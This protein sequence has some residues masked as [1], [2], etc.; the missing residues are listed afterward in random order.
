MIF[1]FNLLFLLLWLF[2]SCDYID[3]VNAFF[4][5]SPN[6]RFE[7]GKNRP[8]PLP[9]EYIDT[10]NFKFLVISDTH[11]YKKQPRYFGRMKAFI[12]QKDVDFIV[13]LGD[14]TQSGRK[15]QFDLFSE[16]FFSLHMPL[17][18]VIGNHDLYNDGYN[19]FL[20]FFGKTNYFL[21]IGEATLIFLD[22]ANGCL[23]NLQKIWFEQI[24][25]ADKDR[26]VFVFAHIGPDGGGVQKPTEMPYPEDVYYFYHINER[27]GTDI[28]SAGHLHMYIDNTVRGCRYITLNNLEEDSRSAFL[29]KVSGNSYST[30]ILSGT[31]SPESFD[32]ELEE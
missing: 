26:M 13:H 32:S 18:P 8:D 29:V 14:I 7:D 27:W 4:S 21:S 17:Y 3:P 2:L 6:S 23:G 25:E 1:R 16:D 30:E 24:L 9:P 12:K 11:Y 10:S 20:D 31:M 15:K 19:H 5:S 22:T 28:F